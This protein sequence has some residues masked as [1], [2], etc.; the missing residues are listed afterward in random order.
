MITSFE[1]RAAKAKWARDN[2]G[3]VRESNRKWR[4]GNERR[5]RL[6]AALRMRRFRAK[7]KRSSR[8]AAAPKD[9]A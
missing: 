3:K 8:P 5:L 2:P 9:L 4:M 7:T 1:R 6:Q